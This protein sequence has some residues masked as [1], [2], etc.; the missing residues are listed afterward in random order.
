MPP[1]AARSLETPARPTTA[2]IWTALVTV[3]FF[4]G[5]TY[6]AIDRSNQ[7]IPVLVGPAIR[8]LVAGGA[9]ALWSRA[10]GNWRR[11]TRREWRDAAIVGALLLF[12]GNAAVAMAEDLGVPT[13]VVSLLIALVPVWI[14]LLDRIV[15]RSGPVGWRVAVGLAGGFAGAALL[16][17]GQLSGDVTAVGLAVA[18]GAS[19]SWACGSL[20]NR[21]ATLPPDPLQASGMQQLT[22]GAV[23]LVAALVSGQAG[24]LDFARVSAESAYALL[25]LVVFGSLL[26]LSAY[27]WLLRNA[28]TSLVATYAYVNPVV[29]VTLGWLVLDEAITR[30]VVLAGGVILVSVALIVSAGSAHRGSG[31]DLEDGA[32]PLPP[33]GPS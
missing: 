3:Y 14:V 1:P 22:G 15:L 26:T 9:L 30:T 2:R 16:V 5:T 24:E 18:I 23:I 32:E 17:R 12:G 21:G 20:Y 7:T 25:Y 28:R 13:G 31:D 8:F 27:L 4:W 19:L 10:R 6:L 29:A 33:E 11:P